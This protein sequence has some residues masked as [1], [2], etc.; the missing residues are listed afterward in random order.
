MVFCLLRMFDSFRIDDVLSEITDR[1]ILR[2]KMIRWSNRPLLMCP[3]DI[4]TMRMC[5]SHIKHLGHGRKCW[6]GNQ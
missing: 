1:Y 2:K 4:P 5:P 3:S 6:L